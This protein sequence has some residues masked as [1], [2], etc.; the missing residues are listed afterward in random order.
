MAAQHNCVQDL[1][2]EVTLRKVEN[3]LQVTWALLVY[4]YVMFCDNV[5]CQ[6]LFFFS[7]YQCIVF[8]GSMFDKRLFETLI[9][10]YSFCITQ[11]VL[12]LLYKPT[13]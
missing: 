3:M 5:A 13:K 11:V 2:S 12:L 7:V 6:A 8:Q 10:T 1:V 9:K 4:F